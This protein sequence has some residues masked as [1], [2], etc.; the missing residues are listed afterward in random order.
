MSL[1]FYIDMLLHFIST[2]NGWVIWVLW[3]RKCT[4]WNNLLHSSVFGRST[5]SKHASNYLSSSNSGSRCFCG[6]AAGDLCQYKP[7][8]QADTVTTLTIF[9]DIRSAC[10]EKDSCARVPCEAW[11]GEIDL[12]LYQNIHCYHRVCVCFIY[13]FTKL[14][15]F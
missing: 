7:L 4:T 5:F 8:Q 6:Q 9:W 1:S 12:H 3:Y 15:N 13:F 14:H 2:A 11:P 10:R